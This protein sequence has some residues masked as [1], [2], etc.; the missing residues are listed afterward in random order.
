[1]GID[2]GGSNLRVVITQDDLT[3]IAQS[4]GETVNPSV[5]GRDRSKQRIRSAVKSVL[6]N[7]NMSPDDLTGIG[8]GIA[9]ASV[10]HSETWLTE[11][12]SFIAP[13]I[14]ATF[15]SDVEIAL[16]GALG[17]RQGVL[18]L[19]GTGSAAYGVN[20]AGASLQVGGWG[21]LIGD[22]GSSYWIGERALQTIAHISDGRM[23][24]SPEF[25][26]DVLKALDLQ[27][28][29]DILRWLY[30]SAQPRNREIA[31]LAPLVLSHATS[32]VYPAIQIVEQATEALALL[33]YTVMTRLEISDR[34]IA[35]AGGILENDN[36]LSRQL[37]ANLGLSDRPVALYPPVIGAVLLAQLKSGIR[38]C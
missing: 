23:S 35:F 15:S 12:A 2:G 20:R 29:A 16:V 28:E 30:Q 21:Y 1:M 33:G 6:A 3:V 22:E 4:S 9:G 31:A 32:G 8:I 26:G 38:A 19:S 37:C 10:V 25:V 17:E 11:V 13:N 7:A 34:K 24:S 14:P 18:I 36:V 5:V 27:A